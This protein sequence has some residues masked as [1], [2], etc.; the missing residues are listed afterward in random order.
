MVVTAKSRVIHA[1][2]DAVWDVLSD[3]K[4]ERGYW[5]NVRDIKVLRAEGNTT[6]RQS[7]KNTLTKATATSRKRH[8][9]VQTI[10]TTTTKRTRKGK[11]S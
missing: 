2:V 6:G 9:K 1:G 4:K 10:A 7:L 3:S 5:T 8:T 11:T